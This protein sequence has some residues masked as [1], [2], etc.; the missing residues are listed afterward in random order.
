MKKPAR[1]SRFEQA[2][3]T[4][5]IVAQPADPLER[6]R[7]YVAGVVR[8]GQELVAPGRS[9]RDRREH[10]TEARGLLADLA[11]EIERLA[12]WPPS[13]AAGRQRALTRR[14]DGGA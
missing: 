8:H 4:A 13:A 2:R 12:G 14:R 7:G 1:L 5:G 3:S 9:A 6:L 11:D 10:Y